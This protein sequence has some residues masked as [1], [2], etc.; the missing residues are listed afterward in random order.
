MLADTTQRSEARKTHQV[1][2]MKKRICIDYLPTL[3]T[4]E[5]DDLKM[6]Q[7]RREYQLS[8][9]LYKTQSAVMDLNYLFISYRLC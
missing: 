1:L 8:L 4:E 2:G 7:G 3:M 5:A 6:G 9:T